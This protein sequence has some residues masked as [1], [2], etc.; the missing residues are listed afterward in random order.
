[1]SHHSKINASLMNK[2]NNLL[3]FIYNWTPLVCLWLSWEHSTGVYCT[4]IWHNFDAH[5]S[6]KPSNIKQC[7]TF[8]HSCVFHFYCL[9]LTRKDL[10]RSILKSRKGLWTPIKCCFV[11]L[12]KRSDHKPFS[13]GINSLH[14]PVF[15]LWP[16]ML[17]SN[18]DSYRPPVQVLDEPNTSSSTALEKNICFSILVIYFWFRL[19]C[20]DRSFSGIFLDECISKEICTNV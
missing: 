16:A 13:H 18:Q 4:I 11:P 2:L 19:S 9:L 15:L 3:C 5:T 10:Q 7:F 8:I 17:A 12:P 20:L 1:M 6:L 14:W